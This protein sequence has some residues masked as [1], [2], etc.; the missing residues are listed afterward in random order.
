MEA[1]RTSRGYILAS[2][3]DH[4][5]CYGLLFFYGCLQ[6]PPVTYIAVHGN[7]VTRIRV[8]KDQSGSVT[9]LMGLLLDGK[10]DGPVDIISFFRG[11][12]LVTADAGDFSRRRCA[13]LQCFKFGGSMIDRKRDH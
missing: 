1:A 8:R 3:A 12:K 4:R 2:Q 6:T 5:F 13:M 7:N 10:F 9:K 11:P